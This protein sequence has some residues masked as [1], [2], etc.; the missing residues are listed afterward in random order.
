MQEA[1]WAQATNQ[2]YLRPTYGL[3][4]EFQLAEIPSHACIPWLIT[5]A[6]LTQ[7][8]L[9]SPSVTLH[10]NQVRCCLGASWTAY[11]GFAQQTAAPTAQVPDINRWTSDGDMC[12]YGA[13]CVSHRL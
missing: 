8:G 4:C 10:I 9:H 12:A 13:S 11:T 1:L 5:A 3:V 2:A 7:V 6:V